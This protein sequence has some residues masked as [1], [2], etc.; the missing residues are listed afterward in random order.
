[1]VAHPHRG[2]VS[3]LVL[4]AGESSRMGQ[5]KALLPWYGRTL[6]EF[7]VET[8]LSSGV[9]QVIVVTG[10]RAEEVEDVLAEQPVEI[11]QNPDFLK[12]KTTSIKAGLRAL[13]PRAQAILL[14][15]V[16]Q[17]RPSQI[18]MRIIREHFE[19]DALITSPRFEGRG[20]HPVIFC[21]NLLPELMAID[22][23]S[24]G[25]RAVYER[26]VN[27]INALP[28]KTPIVLLDMNTPPD[29]RK[30]I[31]LFDSGPVRALF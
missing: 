17:P 16:D 19:H 31:D 30:A 7:Q 27:E 26:H 14:L 22:E 18:V 12:G 20:G 6:I 8:L 1:M 23:V 11:V 4:A 9:D 21:I 10:H 13:D 29:Y 2:F 25:L 5:L 15:H 3:A 24:Q 28:L